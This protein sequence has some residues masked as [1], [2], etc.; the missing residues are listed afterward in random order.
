MHEGLVK[1]WVFRPLMDGTTKNNFRFL[2][3]PPLSLV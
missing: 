1:A 2:A 3:I